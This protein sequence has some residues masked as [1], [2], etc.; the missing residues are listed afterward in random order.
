[1]SNLLEWKEKLQILYARYSTYIDKGIQ[2]ILALTSFLLINNNIGFMQKITGPAVSAGMAL[3]C[4]FFPPV[5]TAA[6]AAVLTLVHMAA[7]SVGIML[8]A[9]VVLL[10]MFIF[11]FRFTPKNAAALLLV[12]IAFSMKM[13]VLIPIVYGLT[14][15]PVTIIPVVFGTIVYFMIHYTKTFAGTINGAGKAQMLEVITGFTKQVFQNKEMWVIV[16]AFVICL[17]LVYTLRRKSMSH[18]WEVAI[19][20]GVAAYILLMA[21][22]NFVMDIKVEYGTLIIGSVAALLIGFV[23]ELMLFS[24][25]YAGTEYV[26]F[27]DDEYYYYV[28]AVPKV[29]VSVPEKKVKRINRRQ[30]TERMDADDIDKLIEQEL[31]KH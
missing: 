12:P 27:E 13:P 4:A 5:V 22:G 23:L 1:M 29:S 26:Q 3:V 30:E 18:A 9:A 17:L 31:L 15:T 10:L 19:I 11:Y 28:K 24:V 25:D 16:A 21:A 2:F 8:V 7:L 6:A 20:S 14:G